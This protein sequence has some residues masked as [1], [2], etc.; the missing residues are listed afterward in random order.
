VQQNKATSVEDIEIPFEL[1]QIGRLKTKDGS[2]VVVKCE[3]VMEFGAL[4]QELG[5]LPGRSG[6]SSAEAEEAKRA[7]AARYTDDPE[8]LKRLMIPLVAAGTSFQRAD[9]TEQRPAFWFNNPI[10]G[11]IPGRVLGLGDIGAMFAAIMRLNGYSGGASDEAAF[12]A[13]GGMGSDSGGDLGA[14]EGDGLQTEHPVAE[15]GAP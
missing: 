5:T 13:G 1:V 2:P 8:A 15:E 6:M 7:A 11:S 9:G 14:S 12:P 10:E 4:M 3:P